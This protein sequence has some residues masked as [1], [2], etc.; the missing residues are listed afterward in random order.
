MQAASAAGVTSLA[1]TTTAA[2][3]WTGDTSATRNQPSPSQNELDLGGRLIVGDEGFDTIQAAWDAASDGDTVYVHSSYDAEAAGESFPIVID[4]RVKEVALA[5]GHPSGSEINAE[6]VPNRNV[7]EV[8][9][10]GINDF[11]NTPLIT[12]LKIV[13]GRVGLQVVGAPNASFSHLKFF[14]TDSHGVNITTTS[15]DDRGTYGTRWYD[16]EA[17]SCGGSGFRVG[18]D[19]SPHGT[20]FIRCNATWNGWNGNHPGV[21]LS[22]FS[23]VWHAGTIQMNSHYGITLRS[24]ASQVIRDTYFESNGI[25]SGYPVQVNANGTIGL[26]I[27]ACY[28]QGRMFDGSRLMQN[29]VG[30]D[31]VSRGITLHNTHTTTLRSCSH[32][33]H[34]DGFVAVQGAFA[35][36]NDIHE[37]SH[38]NIH[39]NDAFLVHDYGSRTRSNG[40][41]CTRDLRNVEGK[42]YC[43][44]GIHDG[45]GNGSFGPAI[46]NGDNW[47][48]IVSG[49]TI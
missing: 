10:R 35:N 26:V 21:Q 20:T 30:H 47:V 14:K 24:G 32:W 7:I 13:G 11:R 12:N 22:G 2:P 27:E 45:S 15:D 1:G 6:H 5:G 29:E 39:G 31:Y 4:Q 36:D 23:S 37:A 46:W 34:S 42:Y 18:A 48:S 33:H 16:C 44:Q 17:W 40:I 43:D 8:Y 38:H 25:E 9:G 49:Q 19:A 41:I 3:L 28:F